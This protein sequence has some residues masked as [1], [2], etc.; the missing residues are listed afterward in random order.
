[1]NP[2][3]LLYHLWEL[4]VVVGLSDDLSQLELDAPQGVLTPELLELIREH[5]EPLIELVFDSLEREAIAGEECPLTFERDLGRDFIRQLADSP[6]L[7]SVAR[8]VGGLHVIERGGESTE[9]YRVF[10]VAA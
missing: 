2:E 4:G 6:V 10:G 3:T 1:M 9:R 8:R 7:L 5:K